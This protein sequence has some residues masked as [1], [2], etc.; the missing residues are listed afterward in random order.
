MKACQRTLSIVILV[1]Q[2]CGML[3]PFLGGVEAVEASAEA[4]ARGTRGPASPPARTPA[5]PSDGLPGA[6]GSDASLTLARTQSAFS[7]SAALSQTLTLTFTV[8]NA[9]PPARAYTPPLTATAPT[10]ASVDMSDDPNVLRNVLLVYRASPSVAPI[11]AAEPQP[12]LQT[13]TVAWNLGDLLPLQRVTVVL[14]LQAPASAADFLTVDGGASA[15]GTSSGRPVSATVGATRIAPDGMEEWLAWTVDADYRDEHLLRQAGRL[16]G[17]WQAMF[18]YVRGL[19][20]EVYRGSLRGTRGTLWSQAGNSLDQTSLLIALL[21]GSGIPARYRHGTLSTADAQTLIGSMF[22]APTSLAGHIPEGAELADP[23]NDPQLLA[24]ASDHWWAEAYLPGL[25]WTDLDPSFAG[26]AVGETFHASLVSDGSDRVAEAPDDE[27][28]KV[29]LSLEIEQWQQLASAGGDL[30]RSFPLSHTMN[31]LELVGR[32]LALDH[33]TASASE[34][35][36]VFWYSETIYEPRLIVGDWERAIDGDTF[37]EITSNFPFGNQA[38]TGEWL[39]VALRSPD[40]AVE[41]YTREIADRLGQDV[42]QNGGSPELELGEEFQPIVGPYDM[43]VVAFD[44]ARVPLDGLRG[45]YRRILALGPQLASTEPISLPNGASTAEEADQYATISLQ[46]QRV[47]RELL[48]Y[49]ASYFLHI[50]S[51]LADNQ[52]AI[53]RTRM[54]AASPRFVIASSVISSDTQRFALD[55]IRTHKRCVVAP[56]QAADTY[57]KANVQRSLVDAYL[58]H[59]TWSRLFPDSEFRSGFALSQRVGELGIDWVLLTA[60]DHGRLEQLSLTPAA[61][62][63]IVAALAEGQIVLAPASM[64]E[65]EHVAWW[66]IDP[67]SFEMV[68]VDENGLH[69]TLAEYK[70][71][72]AKRAAAVKAAIEAFKGADAVKQ[73]LW[74][75]YFQ[76]VNHVDAS[77]GLAGNKAAKAAASKECQQIINSWIDSGGHYVGL[78]GSAEADAIVHMTENLLQGMMAVLW[79]LASDPP[80]PPFHLVPTRAAGNQVAVSNQV[81]TVVGGGSSDGRV[82]LSAPF[83]AW[84]Q[85]SGSGSW[86]APAG[87]H[88]GPT[89]SPSRRRRC[90]MVLARWW[91]RVR[92]RPRPRGPASLSP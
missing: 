36:A 22:S 11:V 26:A 52:M 89:L 44:P 2:I 65:G 58:E 45:N 30:E 62:G 76:A 39:H 28:H 17:S 33:V 50:S 92:C 53:L 73:K 13:E 51:E 60:S 12:S 80:L 84:S 42:R 82:S 38:V 24:E 15:W 86:E 4:P 75:Y 21:R 8:E 49:G 87:G 61:K 27:R 18:D 1:L 90:S 41:T 31:A 23:L 59:D 56:G 32:P 64:V 69:P 77:F 29:T 79:G 9:L 19:D 7:A 16:G 20:Y 55:T 6:E 63:R 37:R 57:Q 67:Q 14:S 72:I 78:Q 40:G 54:V 85:D 88:C 68:P 66:E 48:A 47:S 71:L 3:N 5:R 25:G 70:A 10:S 43:W 81:Q 83:A 74:E 35:G 34:G 46:I 91:A